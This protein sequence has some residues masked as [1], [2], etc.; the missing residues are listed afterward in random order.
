MLAAITRCSHPK[1]TPLHPKVV[2][3]LEVGLASL[4]QWYDCPAIAIDS[5]L[6]GLRGE[7]RWLSGIAVRI[8]EAKNSEVECVML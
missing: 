2:S 7:T 3:L 6:R 8:E 5:S 1:E 4:K